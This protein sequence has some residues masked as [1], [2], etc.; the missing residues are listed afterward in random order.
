MTQQILVILIFVVAL[1]YLGWRTWQSMNRRNA[2]GCGK[3]CGC[4]IDKM[5][6][7]TRR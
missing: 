4:E 1:G 2:G 5:T 3:G 7:S 6:T